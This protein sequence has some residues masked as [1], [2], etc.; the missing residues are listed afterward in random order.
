[1]K[2]LFLLLILSQLYSCCKEKPEELEQHL[3]PAEMKAFWD[4]K[5]GSWWAYQDSATGAIDTVKVLEKINKIDTGVQVYGNKTIIY[6][7]LGIK[8]YNTGDGFFTD[9][10]T[11]TLNRTITTP[12]I[13]HVNKIKYTPSI[14]NG[15]ECFVYPIEVGIHS[16]IGYGFISDSCII[17]DI[18]LSYSTFYNV[19]VICNT[20]NDLEQGN[21]T[22]T[23]YVNG[24]G[25]IRYEV[26]ALNKIKNLINY[27]IIQ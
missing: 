8:T 10:N 15:N 19:L 20:Y 12:E 18:L 11:N 3:I 17:R 13:F 22:T 26:P 1:M 5:P 27:Y 16:N 23:Y 7:F 14:L 24:I 9:Y 6:E 2:K 25:I 21:K 4:F